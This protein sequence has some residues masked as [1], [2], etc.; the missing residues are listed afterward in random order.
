LYSLSFFFS[1][2]SRNEWRSSGMRLRI[3]DR[4]SSAQRFTTLFLRCTKQNSAGRRRNEYGFSFLRRD[5]SLRGERESPRACCSCLLPFDDAFHS[6]CAVDLWR[7]DAIRRT[8]ERKIVRFVA[9]ISVRD[10][11]FVPELCGFFSSYHPSSLLAGYL[12]GSTSFNEVG[13]VEQVHLGLRGICTTPVCRLLQNSM[14]RK[15]RRRKLSARLK[16]FVCI[17]LV[18]FSLLQ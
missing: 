1:V 8:V 7:I 6:T 12:D 16:R 4:R 2:T 18:S 15:K 14:Q 3:S 13:E 11:H 5:K 10:R 9:W 17:I